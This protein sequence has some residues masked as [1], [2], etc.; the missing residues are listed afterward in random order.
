MKLS[1]AHVF[2]LVIAVVLLEV[3][4]STADNAISQTGGLMLVTALV[5]LFADIGIA[6]F[7]SNPLREGASHERT[8][9][10]NWPRP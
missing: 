9:L 5:T 10:R 3:G 4:Q 7:E 6:A 8:P 1:I 2:A